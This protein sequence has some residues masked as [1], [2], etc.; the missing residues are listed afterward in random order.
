MSFDLEAFVANPNLEALDKC[1]KDELTLIAYHYHVD[2]QSAPKKADIKKEILTYLVTNGVLPPF[3]KGVLDTK[4]STNELKLKLIRLELEREA[5]KLEAR[6]IE[7]SLRKKEI[8]ASMLTEKLNA[9]IKIKELE[10]AIL[11][12]DYNQKDPNFSDMK[13]AHGSESTRTD[14]D[15]D[16]T[17]LKSA[18][19]GSNTN[20]KTSS[21]ICRFCK[22][23]GSRHIRLLVSKEE[24]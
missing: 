17:T 10:A 18:D 4:P 11:A 3:D 13:L 9:E 22:N 19:S 6:R 5:Q 24:K 21:L 8:E 12:D 16:Q 7:A 20:S 1:R 15:N 14:T 2:I 23:K